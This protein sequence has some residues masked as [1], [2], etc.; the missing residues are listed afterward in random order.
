MVLR[1]ILAVLVAGLPLGGCGDDAG[2]AA[3]EVDARFV[4]GWSEADH[5]R[6]LLERVGQPDRTIETP[7]ELDE[8][9]QSAAPELDVG[10]LRDV[11]LDEVVIVVGSYPRCDQTSSVEVVD[12]ELRF[13]VVEA[14]DPV[15]CAWAPLQ[16]D[17][18][19][20][21]RDG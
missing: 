18:W 14:E 12:G 20:V 13:V 17:V 15:E 4:V 21:A 10:A 8:L 3:P 19:S 7:A 6:G 9:L 2:S 16:V 11:D 5:D 1:S